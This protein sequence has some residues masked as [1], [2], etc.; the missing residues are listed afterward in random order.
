MLCAAVA[1]TGFSSAHA[2]PLDPVVIVDGWVVKLSDLRP[3]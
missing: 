2:E 3:S 1:L